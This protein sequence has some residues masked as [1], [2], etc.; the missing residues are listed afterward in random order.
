MDNGANNPN[1]PKI[2]SIFLLDEIMENDVKFKAAVK[3]FLTSDY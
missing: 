2:T 1:L 3:N